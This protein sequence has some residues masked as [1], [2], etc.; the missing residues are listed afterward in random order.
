M[1]RREHHCSS[2]AS[3]SGE[4]GMPCRVLA[5]A[6]RAERSPGTRISSTPGRFS[7][8]LD[9]VDGFVDAAQVFGVIEEGADVE[10]AEEVADVL[11]AVEVFVHRAH[12]GAD[13]GTGEHAAEQLDEQSQ[14]VAFM[15][16]H[17]KHGAEER[18]RRIGGGV[19]VAIQGP[20]RGDGLAILLG[21]DDVA[22]GHD[23]GGEVD[24]DREAFAGGERGGDG[25]GAEEGFIS[26]LGRHGRLAVGHGEQD[27]ALRGCVVGVPGERAEVLGVAEGGGGD[28][29]LAGEGDEQVESTAGLHLTGAVAGVKGDHAA[30]AAVDGE[31]GL[32]INEAGLDA[33]EINVEP[34]DTVGGD[35]VQIRID[36]RLGKERRVVGAHAHGKGQARNQ[37]FKLFPGIAVHL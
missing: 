21:G 4:T 10:E 7:G 6:L 31:D 23:G 29:V 16:G 22:A 19:A 35:T 12:A 24:L 17:G 25:V 11:L 15:A 27:K 5:R 26:S 28:A 13:G 18:L 37:T 34:G 20:A 3:V 33:A 36:Q 1:L 9:A 8:G 32:G 2:S 30:G 14:G